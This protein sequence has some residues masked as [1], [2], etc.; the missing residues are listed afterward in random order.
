MNE[1]QNSSTVVKHSTATPGIEGSNL[2]II[3][4]R[5]IWQ[6]LIK[7]VQIYFLFYQNSLAVYIAANK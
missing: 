3:W 6:K 4:H 1:I 2:V 5:I 7:H